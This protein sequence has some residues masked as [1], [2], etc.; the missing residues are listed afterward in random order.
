MIFRQLELPGLFEI[1]PARHGD[2]RGYFS[3]IHRA[4]RFAE[5]I[6]HVDFLQ[7]NQS[8]SVRSG[9]IRGI[10][11]QTEPC[12]QGKL[13]RCLAGAIFDVAVDLRHGS[14]TFG[15]WTAVELTPEA[16]NQLWIPR[17]FG[18]AFCTLQPNSIVC[19][20]VDGYYS[21]PNDAGLLWND[22]AI[23]IAW[24]SVADAGTLSPKDRVQ[25]RLADLPTCFP[26]KG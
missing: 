17:G 20:K 5:H 4:D 1:T 23:G 2:D 9:T 26:F 7:E 14:P 19:Y 15:K 21:A 25:P 13:V 22:P 12:P 24:P 6:G 16:G 11:F 8:L 18:H 10:H 3:E